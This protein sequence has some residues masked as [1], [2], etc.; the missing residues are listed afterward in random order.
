[1]E[2]RSRYRA[3]TVEDYEY[4]AGE[5]SPRVARALCLPPRDGGAVALHLL[6]RVD[7]ADRQLSLEELVPDEALYRTVA[8]Y[9][10]DRRTI[11]TTVTLLPVKLRG[12]SVVVNLQTSPTADV[13]RVEEDV[14]HALYMYLN[15]LI[16]GSPHGPGSG[17]GF[18]RPLNQ[19]ELFGVVHAIPGV[20]FVKILRV[21]ETNVYTGEQDSK[22]AGA[23]IELEP[24]ELLVSGQHIV[25]AVRREQ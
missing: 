5:A 16:G 13:R 22:P 14:S 12:V 8:G 3:V 10:D 24:D 4:L 1:M 6:P 2:I 19:G 20:E 17:W 25:R 21:Y 7:P 15:P 11:G 9:L 18:G 23:H